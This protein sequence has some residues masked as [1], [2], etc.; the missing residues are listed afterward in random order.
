MPNAQAQA[1]TAA[2]PAME[3]ASAQPSPAPPAPPAGAPTYAPPPAYAPAPGYAPGAPLAAPRSVGGAAVIVEAI[4]GFFG[5]FG[6]GWLMS[7]ITTTGLFLL[8]GGIIW[9]VV[10]FFFSITTLGLGFLCVGAVN[11]VVLIVSSVLLNRRLT[12]GR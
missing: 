10:G 7:G 3:A 2:A 4:A 1:E 12:T 5:L 6:I 8:I 9:D 11:V